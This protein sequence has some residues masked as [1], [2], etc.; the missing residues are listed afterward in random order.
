MMKVQSE[1]KVAAM[2]RGSE[3]SVTVKNML[4]EGKMRKHIIS[5]RKLMKSTNK[6]AQYK[7]DYGFG[8]KI[9]EQ[10]RFEPENDRIMRVALRYLRNLGQYRRNGICSPV[11]SCP[12]SGMNVLNTSVNEC[13]ALLTLNFED[14]GSSPWSPEKNSISPFG[15]S[16]ERIQ[17]I[18]H[19][20]TNAKDLSLLELFRTESPINLDEAEQS[21]LDFTKEYRSYDELRFKL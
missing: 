7:E 5:E 12:R 20:G 15:L 14:G 3:L 11:K 2:R 16:D 13:G 21:Y 19:T 18:P 8:D 17:P 9:N 10:E 1:R 6:K 4:K